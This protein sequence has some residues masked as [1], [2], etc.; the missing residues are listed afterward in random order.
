MIREEQLLLMESKL[1]D[2]VVKYYT[3]GR[4]SLGVNHGNQ[5][6]SHAA[7]AGMINMAASMLPQPPSANDIHLQDKFKKRKIASAGK[8][9]K[10]APISGDNQERKSFYYT[11]VKEEFNAF[12]AWLKDE[13][14]EQE[15]WFLVMRYPSK[16]MKKNIDK[17]L[18][19]I[20]ISERPKSTE[21]AFLTREPIHHGH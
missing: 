1:I 9:L 17:E 15:W 5:N 16:W 4:V 13:I 20:P 11:G 19:E 6:N 12:K 21:R 18:S 7:V 10:P 3:S 14:T 8:A 2:R